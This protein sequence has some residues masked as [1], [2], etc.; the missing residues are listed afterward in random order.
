MFLLKK[1]Q[2]QYRNL[3]V[4]VDEAPGEE[5]EDGTPYFTLFVGLGLQ[6]LAICSENIIIETPYMNIC[7]EMQCIIIG[8]KEKNVCIISL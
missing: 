7:N 3:L 1:L 2:Y 6:L 4:L 8:E 5:G